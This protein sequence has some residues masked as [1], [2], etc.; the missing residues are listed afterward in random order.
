[1]SGRNI[2]CKICVNYTYG[3]CINVF[4]V[5]NVLNVLDLLDLLDLWD[6]FDLLC[7]LNKY[8]LRNELIRQRKDKGV[9]VCVC[10]KI[11]FLV[12]NPFTVMFN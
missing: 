11:D 12:A 6:L 9:C 10:V 4:D 5:L 3:K 7:T 2:A 8:F 1:M